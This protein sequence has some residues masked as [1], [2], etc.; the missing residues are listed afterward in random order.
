MGTIRFIELV[1]RMVS[2]FALVDIIEPNGF[3]GA[4][5]HRHQTKQAVIGPPP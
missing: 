5:R 2:N 1:R 4:A 3:A